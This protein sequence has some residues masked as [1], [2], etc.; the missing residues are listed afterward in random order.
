MTEDR[1]PVEHF[2]ETQWHLAKRILFRL[3]FCYLVLYYLPSVLNVIPGAQS[4]ASL[5]NFVW[6]RAISWG[7]VHFFDIDPTQAIPHYTGSGDT[8]LAYLRLCATA[9]AAAGVGT[10]WTILDRR[11]PHYIS[12][13][14]WLRVFARYALAF[15]LFGYAFAKIAPTQFS[16]LQS[17]QLAE[18]YGQSS[19]MALLW[20][21]MGFS[22]PYTVFSGCAELLPAILL[23]F[24]RTA[25]LGS[26]TAF[27]VMLNVVM[28]NFCYDVPVK[29]YSLNLLSLALFLTLPEAQKLLRVF[30]LNR[31]T[32][33]SNLRQP[34]F[35]Q[36]WLQ[37]AAIVFKIAILAIFLF[38]SI[39][40]AISLHQSLASRTQ[41]PPSPL[42]SRGFHW[43]QEYPY[44][45]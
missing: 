1:T 36:L 9:I 26:I 3:A 31:S 39:H 19:P 15:A 33:P 4:L 38:Q 37:R 13:H 11:R 20:N 34:F 42:T 18:S 43:I 2:E 6:D 28:L 8:L 12:L 22:T 44:N 32:A 21:F 25:L 30:V 16:H 35:K 29:L 23:L 45:Q 14:G 40:S 7:L 10:L 17:R 41:P 24:R 5:Y 27:A